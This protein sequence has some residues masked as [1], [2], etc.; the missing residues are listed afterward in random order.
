MKQ[1]FLNQ[2]ISFIMKN[3]DKYTEEDKEK[4]LYGLE[5]LYLTI[6]KA[7]IFIIICIGIDFLKEFL[8]C[9]AIFNIL[10]Y[11]AFGFH[12]NNSLTCLITSGILLIGCPYLCLHVEISF[13]VK[14]IILSCSFII[15]LL[16]APADTVKRPLTNKKKRKMRKIASIIFLLSYGFIMY[17]FPNLTGY[18]LPGIIIETILI[19]PIPYWIFK[20]PYQNYKK[21]DLNRNV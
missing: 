7:I 18:I 5:G 21:V 3:Q 14:T 2:S 4:L 19:S 17:I 9:L 11:P 20:Q 15:F 6:T 8:I 16:C 13:L 12:A 10:R 1:A